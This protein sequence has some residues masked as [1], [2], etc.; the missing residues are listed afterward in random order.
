MPIIPSVEG[1]EDLVFILAVIL[2]STVFLGAGYIFIYYRTNSVSDAINADL[3]TLVEN[4]IQASAP[5]I[6]CDT[7]VGALHRV[8]EELRKGGEYKE[9]ILAVYNDLTL[10][11]NLHIKS[12][13]IDV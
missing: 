4:G 9:R 2:N 13:C 6:R 3:Q 1:I 10:A 7:G 11:G 5:E 8:A 12:G